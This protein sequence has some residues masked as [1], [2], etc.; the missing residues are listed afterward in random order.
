MMTNTFFE[1]FAGGGMARLGLGTN[2]HC[3]LAND[4]DP[5]K[6]RAYQA[7]FGDAETICCDI[8][9]LKAKDMPGKPDLAWASFPCQDLSLAGNRVGL[10]GERSGT[11]WGFW[12]A[13]NKLKL[14]G[15][16]PPLLVLEN[17][18]GL[19]TSHDGQD[20]RDLCRAISSLGYDF[21]AVV[22]DALKFLPQSRPRLFIVCV[23]DKSQLPKETY[24]SQAIDS[25]HSPALSLVARS[26][27]SDLT[28][29]WI[30]WNLPAPEAVIP[31]LAD[32]IDVDSDELL[33]NSQSETNRLLELMSATNRQKVLEARQKSCP[34][35]GTI[36]KRTRVE[37]GHR[38]QRAE[39]RFDGVAGCL[40]TPGGGSSRQ[41][42][43]V[44]DGK[45]VKTRLLSIREAAR[46]MGVS[47]T[48]IIPQNYN[49]G[50]HVFGDGLAV[51]A[52]KH[53]AQHL[54]KPI[55]EASDIKSA[56]Q[57]KIAA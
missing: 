20:F 34:V 7:N 42:I 2:W 31:K 53:I 46:L 27:S 49:D 11:F 5:K 12:S 22:V 29:R 52:V 54:L 17:V 38:I 6:I 15:R 16:A 26:L 19:L 57:R 1:F 56:P 10:A 13:I 18:C 25:W 45:R 48:Y 37:N 32:L 36:Y 39:V 4:I 35:I 8:G 21:G 33:W 55:L 40:R 9:K 28:S 41:S 50:Y 3:L 14:D 43:I 47:D 44:V 24:S 30:W 51:P 23:R